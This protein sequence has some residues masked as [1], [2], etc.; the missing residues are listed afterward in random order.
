LSITAGGSGG[1]GGSKDDL[2]MNLIN[3]FKA[4]AP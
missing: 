4:R 2:V 3:D 1:G